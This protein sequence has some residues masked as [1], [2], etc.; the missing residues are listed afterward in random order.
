MILH[1]K[2]D[3][4]DF[5]REWTLREKVRRYSDYVR[6]PIRLKVERQQPVGDEK[7]EE[8]RPAKT[9]T[10]TEWGQVNKA[11]ALWTRQKS[12]ITEEQYHEFYKHLTHD[13]VEPLAHTHFKVEGL[14]EM[15]GLLFVPKRAPLGFLEKKTEGLRLFVRRVFILD[16]ADEL[17]PQWLRFVRGVVDSD[18]LPLNVSREF[19]Q[20][21]RTSAAI[22]KQVIKQALKMLEEVAEEGET[23]TEDAEGEETKVNRYEEFWNEFGRVLKEGVHFEADHRERIAKLLRYES[24]E[25]E[26][27]TSLEGYVDRMAEDQKVIYYLAAETRGAA[28]ASPH[29]EGLADRG[30]EVLYMLDPVDEWV[31]QSL[32]EFDGKELVS[33]AKGGLDL[34]ESDEDKE[35]R[36]KLA[37]EFEGL[38]EAMTSRLGEHVKE[39]RLSDRLTDSPACLVGE[40]QDLPPHIE[41]LLRANNQQVPE[42]KRVLELNADHV[43][44]QRLRDL[45]ADE[46][47][48]DQVG[49]W[50]ELLYDQA[51]VAEGSPPS[52]PARFARQITSLL[53]RATE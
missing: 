18:D 45:A 14:Q 40:A 1:L 28:E 23:T 15:T 49:E 48:A 17:L 29:I 51:L 34:P 33:A 38:I 6:H 31:V 42:S 24:S 35:E 7:D 22:R 39:V 10:V 8:G 52:D 53:G 36:E 20:K 43:V 5:L 2:E 27:L 50:T 37:G 19:L 26:G 47:M 21:D 41:R 32:R 30:Y 4:D 16:D 12:E 46:A 9:E 3:E 13:W 11:N 25:H 44:V